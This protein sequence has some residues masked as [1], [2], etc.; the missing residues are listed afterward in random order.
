MLQHVVGP[1]C[2]VPGCPY[3]KVA[4]HYRDANYSEV[5]E[6]TLGVVTS[7]AAHQ[8]MVL[9]WHQAGASMS[10]QLLKASQVRGLLGS[11]LR[12]YAIAGCFLQVQRCKVLA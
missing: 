3:W 2:R 7:V 4:V 8:S 1:A 12:L 10:C 9:K 5:W 11:E 6:A